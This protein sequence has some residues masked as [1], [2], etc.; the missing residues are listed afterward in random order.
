M[1]EISEFFRKEESV[2]VWGTGAKVWL[3]IVLV[4]NVLS[5]LPV[6]A[7]IALMPLYAIAVIVLE[8]IL[9]VGVVLLLFKQQKLGFYI[10]CAS[11]VLSAIFNVMLGTNIIRAVLSA[12]LFPL[13]TYLIIKSSW[14]ELA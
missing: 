5:C 2:M 1:R 4:I 8:L 14:N 3:W 9:I 10:L 7:L 11:S 6:F 13:I 12:V